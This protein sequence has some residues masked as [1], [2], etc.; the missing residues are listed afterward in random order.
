[1][2]LESKHDAA[3]SYVEGAK[4]L[5]KASPAEAVPLLQQVRPAPRPPLA[6]PR[7]RAAPGSCARRGIFGMP[8]LLRLCAAGAAK[9]ER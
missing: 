2:K 1:M 4:A 3:S 8:V 9:G 5:M 7:P 6:R